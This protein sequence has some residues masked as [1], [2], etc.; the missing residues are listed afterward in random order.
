MFTPK[1]LCNGHLSY[2]ISTVIRKYDLSKRQIK[3]HLKKALKLYCQLL[4]QLTTYHVNKNS[5]TYIFFITLLVN[6]ILPEQVQGIKCFPRDNMVSNKSYGQLG[7]INWSKVSRSS[8]LEVFCKKGVFKKF[9]KFT[10]KCLCC[11][12][13]LIKL[14]AWRPATS[15]KT[16]ISTR[17]NIY[18][19]EHLQMAAS[20]A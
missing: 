2:F 8:R 5:R 15:S 20:L 7:C 4:N 6:A 10:W 16:D 3:S 18:F 17:I 1:H 19:V 11:R 9:A 14:Q 13:L 12:I